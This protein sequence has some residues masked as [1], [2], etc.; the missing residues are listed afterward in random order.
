MRD[1]SRS[2]TNDAIYNFLTVIALAVVLAV[3]AVTLV[4]YQTPDHPFNPFPP[5]TLPVALILPSATVT[6]DPPALVET[7]V[8]DEPVEQAVID[9]ATEP[10]QPTATITRTPAPTSTSTP[11]SGYRYQIKG[12]PAAINA[13]IFDSDRDNCQWMGVAGQ[14]HD[15]KDSPV[16]G[17]LVLLGGYLDG[18][19]LNE[20]TMTGTALNYG[21]AGYEF[22][23]ADAPVA[24]SGKTW[25]QLVD[26][27]YIPL[28]AKVY[29]DTYADG[30]CGKNLIIINFKQVR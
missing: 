29:F 13:S 30:D 25:I 5:P 20:I 23:L 26:Q 7:P 19:S 12:E 6:S 3:V 18:K 24:S 17:I 4:I 9:T 16:T 2:H 21:P 10:P 1:H 11:A 27:S 14:V 28:S 15:L 22:K 8:L